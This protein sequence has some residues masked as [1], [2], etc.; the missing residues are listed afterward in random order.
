M[1]NVNYLMDIGMVK[2]NASKIKV[3]LVPKGT[4]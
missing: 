4:I 3:P 1:E 2:L